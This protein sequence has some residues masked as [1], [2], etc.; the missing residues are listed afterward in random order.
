[1]L[2]S[3]SILPARKRSHTGLRPSLLDA[4]LPGDPWAVSCSMPGVLVLDVSNYPVALVQATPLDQ[5]AMNG[6]IYRLQN[7]RPRT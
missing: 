7:G 6:W 4:L 2:A 1:M 3:I 5:W